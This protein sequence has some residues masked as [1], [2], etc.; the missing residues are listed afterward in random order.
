MKRAVHLAPAASAGRGANIAEGASAPGDPSPR[1]S[2]IP[3]L[4]IVIPCFNEQEA[5]PDTLDKILA[6]RS[7]LLVEGAI[8]PASYIACIVDGSSDATW[9]II[10]GYY[11]K[12]D[13][14]VRGLKLS[15]NFGH[16]NALIAGLH[17]FDFD[18]AI[19]ID[20][21][22]QDPPEVIAEMVAKYVHEGYDIV[23]G[24][25]NDRASDSFLKRTTAQL[26]YQCL[27]AMRVNLV[28]NHADFRLLSRRVVEALSEFGEY[29]LFLRGV[30]P[31]IGFHST[32]VYYARAKRVDGISKYPLRKMLAFAWDGITSLSTVPLA[33]VTACGLVL[34]LVS[35]VLLL[36]T[37]GM[38]LAGRAVSGELMLELA[39]Y[40]VTGV[41]L[42]CL[43]II[44]QYV[45]RIYQEVKKRPRFI[46]EQRL[47]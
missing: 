24:V 43:G 26:Y 44:G 7:R 25:R 33:I 32:V 27:R 4:V 9:D 30:I 40:L 17:S 3:V 16:Q 34:F 28:Y 36:A 19:T 47:P 22:Q 20:A 8:A 5:L 10:S 42:L 29:H 6:L 45:G 18:A 15:R 11:E 13:R 23:Y 37:A 46:V 38:R 41:N 2:R 1:R 39:E 35:L 12:T 14:A 21:D 31:Y